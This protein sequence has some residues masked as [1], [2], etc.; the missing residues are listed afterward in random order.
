MSCPRPQKR[1]ASMPRAEFGT[2]ESVDCTVRKAGP[3]GKTAKRD[4]KAD[5][6]RKKR[7]VT[8]R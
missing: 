7:F 5:A 3:I 2:S 4:S 8:L 1:Q 6:E